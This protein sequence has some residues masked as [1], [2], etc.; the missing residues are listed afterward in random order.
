MKFIIIYRCYKIYKIYF[1]YIW[2][3]RKA[4]IYKLSLLQIPFINEFMVLFLGAP[5]L[6]VRQKWA[7]GLIDKMTTDISVV[8]G[9][10]DPTLQQEIV[11]EYEY[12]GGNSSSRLFERSRIKAL[13]GTKLNFIFKS[14]MYILLQL[15]FYYNYLLSFT[16]IV[17]IKIIVCDLFW[18]C[19]K[20]VKARLRTLFCNNNE[21][22]YWGT[23]LF[24]KN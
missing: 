22:R 18:F 7:V 17:F 3:K 10:W 19:N 24:L 13:A 23:D 14:F 16:I 11:D 20:Y 21:W 12:D 4:I 15:S 8:R 2:R 6:G 5:F 9:G 1:K